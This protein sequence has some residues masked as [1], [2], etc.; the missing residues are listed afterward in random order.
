MNRQTFK[1][2]S[3][4]LAAIPKLTALATIRFYQRTF[5]PD[6]GLAK[7]FFPWGCCKFHP[8]CSEYA[9]GAI[10]E[11]GLIKGWLLAGWRLLR[12]HPWSDGGHDP[13]PKRK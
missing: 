13:V 1:Y 4:M 2:W 5:S 7:V 10:Q 12:C 8:T 3:T 11:H 6:H 9:Y